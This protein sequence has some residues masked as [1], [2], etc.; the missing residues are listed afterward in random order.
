MTIISAVL[1]QDYIA[2]ASDSF[3]TTPDGDN[4]RYVVLEDKK[5]KIVYVPKFF[6]A[7]SWCGY[8]GWGDDDV[9]PWFEARA[10][11]A[12]SKD[13]AEEFAE[14]LTAELNKD[15]E[16][17]KI[18]PGLALHFAAYEPIGNEKTLVPEL[19][20]IHTYNGAYDVE[21]S[22]KVLCQRHSYHTIAVVAPDASHRDETFRMQV[23]ERVK[24]GPLIY[25]NPEPN[26]FSPL[27][28]LIWDQNK[29]FYSVDPATVSLLTAS[30]PIRLVAHTLRYGA[31]KNTYKIGGT[32]HCL[33]IR[34][35]GDHSWHRFEDS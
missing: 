14:Y 8:M 31:L 33:L 35:T 29:A 27:A 1:G 5:P 20:Y 13:S 22:Q 15:F 24:Q 19:F 12:P 9:L 30:Q 26:L 23:L 4:E 11:Q 17:L 34:K 2:V 25:N 32:V 6:G 7:I 10:A 16:W 18:P 3:R 21:P 28:K